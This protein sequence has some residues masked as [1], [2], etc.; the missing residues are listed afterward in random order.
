[1]LKVTTV[2]TSDNKQGKMAPR[3]ELLT[4]AQ[5]KLA[6]VRPYTNKMGCMY[7]YSGGDFGNPYICK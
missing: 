4:Y 2:G 7:I 1:M 6:C 5:I 3:M